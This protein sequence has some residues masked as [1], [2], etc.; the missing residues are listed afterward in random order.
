MK[1]IMIS[2]ILV[3]ICIGYFACV[4]LEKQVILIIC[5]ACLKGI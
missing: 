1:T 4:A 5:G 2:T 3:N